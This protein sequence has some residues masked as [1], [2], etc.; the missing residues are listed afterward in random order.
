ML[1][2]LYVADHYHLCVCTTCIARA[3]TLVQHTH[4]CIAPT[5][6]QV[7]RRRKWFEF[8]ETTPEQ[9]GEGLYRMVSITEDEAIHALDSFSAEAF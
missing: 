2:V 9:F 4:T 5:N 3:H 6:T 7:M 1:S 8:V